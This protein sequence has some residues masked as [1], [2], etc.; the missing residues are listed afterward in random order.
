VRRA[1]GIKEAT[2]LIPV[3]FNDGTKVPVEVLEAIEEQ[4]LVAFGGW[5]S[6][7]TVRGAYRMQSG[8]ERVER[9]RKLSVIVEE[10]QV[11]VLETMV[12]RWGAILGQEAM[13]LKVSDL[14]VKFVP[15]GSGKESP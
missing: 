12:A 8:Q 14:I 11:A 2:I 3:T 5:T 13:L 9:L 1:T 15:P 6:E 10:S 7:G 4:L